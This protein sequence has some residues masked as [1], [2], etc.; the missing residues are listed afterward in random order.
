M[1][2]THEKKKKKKQS[3]AGLW[4]GLGVGGAVLLILLIVGVVVIV[5][6]MGDRGD[7]QAKGKPKFDPP[8]EPQPPPQQDPPKKDPPK[9]VGDKPR[10]E[11]TFYLRINRIERLNELKQIGIFYT[12]YSD[13]FNRPPRNADEFVKYIARDAPAIAKAIQDKYYFIVPNARS[14]IMA[15]EFQ[16]DQM[17][18]HGMVHTSEGVRD[19][20]QVDLLAT[21]KQQG[22][23]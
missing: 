6:A 21:L 18:M 7:A 2:T 20:S 3:R 15:Y 23:Q 19:I 5:L 17:K 10:T 13:T 12:Q 1:A 8:V 4:I 11:G 16:P 9:D 22:G 14:G